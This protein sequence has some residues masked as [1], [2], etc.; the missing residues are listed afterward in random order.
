MPNYSP[1]PNEKN[2][3]SRKQRK[4]ARLKTFMDNKKLAKNRKKEIRRG[5]RTSE[6]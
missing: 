1:Y 4:G 3:P 6:E 5:K 2:T